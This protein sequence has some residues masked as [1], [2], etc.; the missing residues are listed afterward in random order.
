MNH[1]TIVLAAQ[2]EQS[3]PSALVLIGVYLASIPMI[4]VHEFGHL[5][6][7]RLMGMRIT[8]FNVGSGK[9]LWQR[10]FCGIHFVIRKLPF[11]G[12]VN[13]LISDSTTR[14]S[15]FVFIAGGPAINL[16]I[17]GAVTWWSGENIYY[18]F[19]QPSIASIFI[20]A[21][22]YLVLATLIPIAD[23]SGTSEARGSD[24]WLL[25]RILRGK[26]LSLA[27]DEIIR[28][29]GKV[30]LSALQRHAR[31]TR[32]V[33]QILGWFLIAIALCLGM[34]VIPVARYIYSPGD[35]FYNLIGA[36]CIVSVMVIFSLGSLVMGILLLRKAW[37]E[38]ANAEA[39]KKFSPLREQ[40]SQ[41]RLMIIHQMDQWKF[42]DLPEDARLKLISSHEDNDIIPFLQDLREKWPAIPVINLMLYDSY[43]PERRYSE[44]QKE[45]ST[46]L[47]RDDLPDLLRF[48]FET[49][50]LS[51][52][53]SASADDATI[54][55][56]Q[57]MIDSA[58]DDGLKMWRVLDLS[59]TIIK[60]KH[61]H[62]MDQATKWCE[63]AREIYP[64]DASVFLQ[65]AVIS[66]E[67]DDI[68][69]AKADLKRAKELAEETN[70]SIVIAYLA[71]VAALDK[72]PKAAKLLDQSLSNPLPLSLKQRLKEA[73][74]NLSSSGPN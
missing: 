63:Q 32:V 9:V 11:S 48:H 55:R 18:L 70:K 15:L 60:A 52:Q 30:G 57:E 1:V 43:M 4:F 8:E 47:E 58:T 69:S 64:Y 46:A 2:S 39:K 3:I 34:F 6:A 44:A 72:D 5:I 56:C 20:A 41:Y 7:G 49:C 53:L 71:I 37:R 27:P 25:W 33:Q 59:S 16:L 19:S 14:F 26:P 28:L 13:H 50:L 40:Y 10:T 36:I 23:R 73:R 17:A 62:R 29:R 38:F 21:N 74:Q 51:A 31:L 68:E 22:L 45:I 54:A 42:S 61:S 66:I 24:G 65:S 35:D 67:Q 12:Y